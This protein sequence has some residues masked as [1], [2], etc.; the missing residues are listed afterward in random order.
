[1][2]ASAGCLHS[3]AWT[4]APF[5]ATIRSFIK[6]DI[7][8]FTW[9]AP[10]FTS[11]WVSKR[12][13]DSLPLHCILHGTDFFPRQTF[14]LKY[15]WGTGGTDDTNSSSVQFKGTRKP[16][17]WTTVHYIRVMEQQNLNGMQ[18]SLTLLIAP[19]LFLLWQIWR[20]HHFGEFVYYLLF[21]FHLW[22]D[23]K[24]HLGWFFWIFT[25][26]LL[27]FSWICFVETKTLFTPFYQ[28]IKCFSLYKENQGL[29][30][31]WCTEVHEKH[32]GPLQQSHFCICNVFTC[33]GR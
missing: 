20:I 33:T 13:Q 22:T 7:I 24:Y 11:L 27:P 4:W 5:W 15:R 18:P 21:I 6:K 17:Q 30:L 31:V 19:V 29:N 28:A 16:S 8:L 1:M 3:V 12:K 9:I 14:W 2:G 26:G 25:T 32:W 23:W 10:V